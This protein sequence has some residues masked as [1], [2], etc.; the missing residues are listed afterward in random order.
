MDLIESL[1][2]YCLLQCENVNSK[3]KQCLLISFGLPLEDIVQIAHLHSRE[4]KV[5]IF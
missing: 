1:A 2:A 5:T 3:C 4:V